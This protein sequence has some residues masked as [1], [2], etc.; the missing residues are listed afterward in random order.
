[1]R[2]CVREGVRGRRK[3]TTEGK[4]KGEKR[5]GQAKRSGEQMKMHLCI[6]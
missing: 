3:Q 2:V 5:R 1:M 6:P 4:L